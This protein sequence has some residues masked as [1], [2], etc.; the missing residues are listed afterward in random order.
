MTKTR[1]FAAAMLTLAGCFTAAAQN[2]PGQNQE[3]P[4]VANKGTTVQAKCI[5]EN[6]GYKRNGK[7]PMFV[8]ELTNKCTRPMTCKVFAFITSARGIA[9]GH[10][11][12]KLAAAAPGQPTKGT[13]TM[14]AKGMGGNSQ[15]DREC[16]AL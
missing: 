12:I 16:R 10:G 3:P 1:L 11:T 8:I 14:R 6:D 7:Q 13:F 15:S 5:D 4:P 2:A 9:Q